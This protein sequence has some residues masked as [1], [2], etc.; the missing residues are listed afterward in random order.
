[1][2][3]DPHFEK[4][5]LGTLHKALKASESES[6]SFLSFP[7]INVTGSLSGRNARIELQLKNCTT[8]WILHWGYLYRGD[9]NW[10]IPVD[11]PSGTTP[12]MQGAMQT[13]FRKNGEVY[14]L[15]IELWDPNIHAIEFVLK[16]GSR[17]RWLKL[18]HGNFRIEIPE[19]DAT[20]SIWRTD[21]ATMF[22]PSSYRM[23]YLGVRIAKRMLAG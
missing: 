2:G 12:Y 11:H 9:I 13:P 3:I 15:I 4:W 14:L 22:G 10:F 21:F 8:T 16:D 7:Q 1:M 19:N 5:K 18:N 17:D 6:D 20:P 23:L